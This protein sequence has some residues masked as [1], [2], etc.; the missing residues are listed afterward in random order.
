MIS[1]LQHLPIKINKA[2]EEDFPFKRKN[3]IIYMPGKLPEIET[4][5]VKLF[6][7]TSLK[8]SVHVKKT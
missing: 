5:Q 7:K 4:S 3:G 8:K 6:L 2:Y 1:Y